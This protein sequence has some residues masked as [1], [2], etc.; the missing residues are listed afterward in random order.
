[1]LRAT[2]VSHLIRVSQRSVE[3]YILILLR[4]IVTRRQI[5]LPRKSNWTGLA[6]V[7]GSCLL[8]SLLLST[9][10]GFHRGCGE[11]V[12]ISA[13]CQLM[14]LGWGEALPSLVLALSIV[15]HSD[16]KRPVVVTVAP[17]AV[18]HLIGVVARSGTA[19][20]FLLFAENILGL[21]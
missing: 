2:P 8:W 6:S 20:I 14:M 9:A 12:T 21:W 1:M 5:D 15:V 4:W 16:A 11:K 19:G 10:L 18:V 3:H 13:P 17:A 7:A